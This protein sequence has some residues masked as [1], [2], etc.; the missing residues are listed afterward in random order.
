[1]FSIFWISLKKS[2]YNSMILKNHNKVV[3]TSL[4][5]LL[6]IGGLLV[7]SYKNKKCSIFL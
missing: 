6:S 4:S 7:K 2:N 1:M 3:Y 5:G